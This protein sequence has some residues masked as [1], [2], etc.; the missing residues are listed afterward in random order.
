M[1]QDISERRVKVGGVT[2]AY[3]EAGSG[4]MV[5]LVH[6]FPDNAWT[7]EHQITALAKKGFRVVAP[8]LRGYPP[9]DVPASPPDT[10]TLAEDL[11]GVIDALGEDSVHVIGHDWGGFA[12][13]YSA[14]LFPNHVDSGV[15]IGVGHPATG[16][17]IFNSAARLHYSFHVW[18]FQ[19]EGVGE[20]ALRAND[21]EMIDYLWDHWSH[22][23]VDPAHVERVKETFRKTGVPEAALAYYKALLH[24]PSTKPDFF[25]KV[26]APTVVPIMVVYG[27]R[28]PAQEVS[29]KERR[30]FDGPYRR[31]LVEGAGHF[32][33]RE[34]PNE[35][36][37][38]L[39]DWL[40]DP[41]QP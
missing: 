37:D 26:T 22:Q 24:T 8:F 11:I 16:A 23:P 27:K 1:S 31:E 20:L 10:E 35:L 14:A 39:L 17:E 25:E 33:H 40:P 15:S 36:T 4:P 28:D 38:L 9:S 13:F 5:L 7:W 32:V 19:L 6:G 41:R 12:V 34:R 3:L 21:F 30:F 29:A 2:L 18:L